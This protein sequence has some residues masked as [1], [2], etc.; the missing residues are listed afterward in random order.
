MR[1]VPER[2]ST[3][4]ALV[5]EKVGENFP[6]ENAGAKAPADEADKEAPPATFEEVVE[7]YTDLVYNVAY[8]YMGIPHDAEDVVQ[9][10]FLSAYRAWG[11]FRGE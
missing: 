11:R 10:A 9:D 3:D 2:F 7:R 4:P 1:I 6:L 8:R 5:G